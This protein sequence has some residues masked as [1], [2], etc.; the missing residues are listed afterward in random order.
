MI[1]STRINIKSG[2]GGRGLV[3][4]HHE[5]YIPLGGPDGGDGGKGGDVFFQASDSVTDLGIIKHLA[6]FSAEDGEEGGGNN[7][8]GRNGKDAILLV[9]RGTAVL[10]VA[11]SGEG[12][13]VAD[14]VDNGDKIIVAKGG[15]GGMGNS[16]FASAVNQAPETATEGEKGERKVFLLE[17]KLPTDV[18]II[19]L[20][21]AGK[22]TLLAAVSL[23]RPKVAEY[24]FTTR[25]PVL[26]AIQDIKRNFIIAEIPSLVKG[27]HDGKGLGNDFLCHVERTRLIIYL[28]D[29]T[30][31]DIRSDWAVLREE[32]F[33]YRPDLLR[34]PMVVA[35][36]KID[37]AQVRKRLPEIKRSLSSLGV[38]LFYVAAATGEGVQDLFLKVR[39]II[40]GADQ[41]KEE[42]LLSQVA[43]FHPRPKR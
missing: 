23:A 2:S 28:L 11:N 33:L 21:N 39:E 14:L 41:S 8:H 19:G 7:R 22:S 26:G 12:H 37:L 16:R 42:E 17:I 18:C 10:E 43:V 29:G 25:Q 32:L 31:H 30:S 1:I 38:S 35:I 6:E 27:A 4:F 5:K 36:N 13:L 15:R 9:P 3:K 40:E 24:P 20:A 34:K